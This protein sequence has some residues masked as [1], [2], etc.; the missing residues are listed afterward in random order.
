MSEI[1]IKC[2]K[3]ES[4]NLPKFAKRLRYIEPKQND[5]CRPDKIL[6]LMASNDKV[7]TKTDKNRL[8]QDYRYGDKE[9]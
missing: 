5:F 1:T 9:R 3:L 7:W 8:T 6:N 2:F 4:Y